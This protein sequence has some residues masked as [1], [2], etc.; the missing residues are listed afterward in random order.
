MFYDMVVS[1]IAGLIGKNSAQPAGLDT[2]QQ[3]DLASLA[4]PPFPLLSLPLEIRL[5]VFRYLC[6]NLYIENSYKTPKAQRYDG[7]TC[8]TAIL[9]INR[10]LYLEVRDEWYGGVYY[11]ARIHPTGFHMHGYVS[12]LYREPPRTLGYIRCLDLEIQLKTPGWMDWNSD[13]KEPMGLYCCKEFLEKSMKNERMKKLRRLRLSFGVSIVCFEYYR[14][15]IGE[16]KGDLEREMS[17]LKG[18]SGLTEVRFVRIVQG[19]GYHGTHPGGILGARGRR[20]LEAMSVVMKQFVEALTA[21]ITIPDMSRISLK[22][23]LL[24]IN[25]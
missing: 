22:D 5:Q 8:N 19:Y 1:P 2:T 9:L 14:D 23:K 13:R 16:L 15:K 25:S 11:R 20:T 6:P 3:Q 7:Y 10:Q 24:N 4:A 17:G 12:S 21:E 18:L